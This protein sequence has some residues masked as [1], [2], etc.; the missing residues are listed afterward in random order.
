MLT[1]SVWLAVAGACG[2]VAVAAA[3][4]LVWLRSS[5]PP[6]PIAVTGAQGLYAEH[7]AVC[8]GATG[9]GDG[10]GARVLGRQMPDF[11]DAEAMRQVN[12]EF[13]FEIIEKGGSQFGRSNAMPAWGM[14]LSDAEIR[15]LVTLIRSLARP[16][17][18]ETS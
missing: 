7:C 12:D 16:V 18:K 5:E 6:R 17:K 13:L 10:P 4:V 8:H 15:D 2:V 3:A 9:K 1:R 11:T 14:R